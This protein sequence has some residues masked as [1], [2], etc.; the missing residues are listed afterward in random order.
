MKLFSI[1]NLAMT[2][3]L[4]VAGLGLIG[5]GAHAVF[6]SNT[7]SSQQITTGSPDITL[8]GSCLNGTICTGNPSDLYSVGASTL[9]FTAGGP[10][11]STF[12]TGDEQ[13]TLTNTGTIPVTETF[14]DVTSNYPTAPLAMDSYICVTTTGIYTGGNNYLVYN[15][16][17]GVYLAGTASTANPLNWNG[18]PLSTLQP[19]DTDNYVINV[20]AG[21]EPTSCGSDSTSGTI[22][23]PGT[24]VAPTL[25]N[26][27]ENQSLSVM[28]T[29]NYTS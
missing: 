2:G 24:S 15:G 16:P 10:T 21:S 26:L 5:V 25:N 9:S 13:V 28:A 7:V 23:T 11:G 18:G 14:F 27:D 17:L 12:S 6:T 3:A 20:Y 29:M 8:T 22:A 19:G 1:R 4:S